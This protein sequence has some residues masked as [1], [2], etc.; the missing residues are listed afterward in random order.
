MKFESRLKTLLSAITAVMLLSCSAYLWASEGAIYPPDDD[1][2]S[3]QDTTD[4][5]DSGSA[6]R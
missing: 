2:D 5:S 1:A 3:L 4:D 6:A